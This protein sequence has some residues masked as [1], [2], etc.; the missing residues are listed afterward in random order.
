MIDFIVFRLTADTIVRN[1]LDLIKKIYFNT[2]AGL[3]SVFNLCVNLP[4]L[5]VVEVVNLAC[6]G[7]FSNLI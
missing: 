2:L 5:L 3:V 4:D 6:K 1:F 7:I